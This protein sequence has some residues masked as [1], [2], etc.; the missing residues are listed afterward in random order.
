MKIKKQ[1]D[2]WKHFVVDDFLPQPVFNSVQSEM[3]SV[4]SDLG[5]SAKGRKQFWFDENS[6]MT[7]TL[8]SYVEE[9]ISEIGLKYDLEDHNQQCELSVCRPR[10]DYDCIHTD[11]P[12]KIF[13]TVLYLSNKG[14]GTDLYFSESKESYVKTVEWKPNRAICFSRSEH[15]WH[16]FHALDCTEDRYTVN[17]IL[18]K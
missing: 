13:T 7:Y 14:S 16:N 17:L 8:F 15:T 2:P 18:R 3:Y 6:S 12:E 4:A 11:T 9:I 1:R 10:Y 5:F